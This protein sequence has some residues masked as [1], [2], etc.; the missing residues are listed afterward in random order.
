MLVNISA[1]WIAKLEEIEAENPSH[2]DRA[3]LAECHVGEPIAYG[4]WEI[5]RL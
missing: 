4:V 5:L 2:P 3:K 1:K